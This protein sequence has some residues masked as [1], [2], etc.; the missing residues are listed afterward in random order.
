MLEVEFIPAIPSSLGRVQKSNSRGYETP[1]KTTQ[2]APADLM[3]A[4][5]GGHKRLCSGATLGVICGHYLQGSAHF[6]APT[7]ST[8]R[9][10]WDVCVYMWSPLAWR[11]WGLKDKFLYFS[12]LRCLDC[13]K[14][15]SLWKPSLQGTSRIETSPPLFLC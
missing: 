6:P 2:S 8:A 15:T 14:N 5:P 1:S 13:S 12:L 7:G 9:S 10:Y 4:L 3:L 11:N